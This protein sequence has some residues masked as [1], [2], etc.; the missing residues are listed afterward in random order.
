MQCIYIYILS[1]RIQYLIREQIVEEAND[2]GK[3]EG[4]GFIGSYS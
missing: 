1:F 2:P 3:K 4:K